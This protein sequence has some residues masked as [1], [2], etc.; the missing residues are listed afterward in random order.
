M[1]FFG[2]KKIEEPA[3]EKNEEAVLKEEL[4]G[5]VEKLQKEFRGK[6]EE[7]DNITQKIETV[8]KEYDITTSNI[9]SVKKELNQEKM[10]LDIVP[11]ALPR[12]VYW[13]GVGARFRDLSVPAPALGWRYLRWRAGM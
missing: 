13:H 1:G 12:C 8:R 11:A 6:Q 5:E 10:E 3:P 7:L 2:K 4:E 9:M